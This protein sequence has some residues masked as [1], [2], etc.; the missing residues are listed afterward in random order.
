VRQGDA[1]VYR[2]AGCRRAGDERYVRFRAGR[3]AVG[4]GAQQEIGRPKPK[5]VR[6]RSEVPTC[7]ATKSPVIACAT[8][9]V[10]YPM[11]CVAAMQRPSSAQ[12]R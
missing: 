7:I 10:R 6:Q 4:R 9:S 3:F 5:A 1:Q 2:I 8:E 12:L 11:D